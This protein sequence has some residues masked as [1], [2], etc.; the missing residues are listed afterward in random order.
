M[1]FYDKYHSFFMPSYDK[2]SKLKYI[3]GA[4]WLYFV[5]AYNVIFFPESSYVL[6]PFIL[7]ISAVIFFEYKITYLKK[8]LVGVEPVNKYEKKIFYTIFYAMFFI[9][10]IIIVRFFILKFHRG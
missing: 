1:N 4:I 3:A 10:I 8:F 6:M 5:G 9:N 2:H 7:A